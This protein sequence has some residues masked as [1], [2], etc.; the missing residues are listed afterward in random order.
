M[1]NLI[2]FTFVIT[3]LASSN[4]F[5]SKD[6]LAKCGPRTEAYAT[7]AVGRK[8]DP[9]G[10]EAYKCE[11]AQNKAVVLCELLASKGDGDAHDTYRAVLNK[12]CTRVLRLDV[13][14]IE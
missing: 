5:A 10:I 6:L 1:K 3:I 7:A 2:L 11:I 13:I 12:S 4:L 14:G 9:N 8:Y